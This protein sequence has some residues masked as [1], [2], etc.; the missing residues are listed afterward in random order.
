MG[1]RNHCH[2]AEPR[3]PELKLFSP[4]L[5]GPAAR[6]GCPRPASHGGP[7]AAKALFGLQRCVSLC[8]PWDSNPEPAD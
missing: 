3:K 5:Q 6:S 7:V 2:P 1:Q 8:A 4:E